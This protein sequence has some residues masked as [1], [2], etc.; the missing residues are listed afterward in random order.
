LYKNLRAEMVRQNISYDDIASAI[1]KTK[2]AV[3]RKVSDTTK[4]YI[5][6]CK[7]IASLFRENNELDYLFAKKTADAPTTDTSAV[8]DDTAPNNTTSAIQK[9]NKKVAV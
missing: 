8:A 4:I 7:A 6:E 1:G 9:S 5:C 2:D 3:I